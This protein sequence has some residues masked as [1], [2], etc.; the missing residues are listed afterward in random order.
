M[1]IKILCYFGLFLCS[2]FLIA[3]TTNDYYK[4]ESDDMVVAVYEYEPETSFLR[5]FFIIENDN[6]L[7]NVLKQY[8]S[9]LEQPSFKSNIDLYPLEKY[10]YFI[11]WIRTNDK[12]AS[13]TQNAI[14]IDNDTGRVHTDSKLSFYNDDEDIKYWVLY[15]IVDKEKLKDFDFS[16]QK[17][18]PFEYADKPNGG[19]E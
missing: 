18:E 8:D 2:I 17:K 9:F 6:D 3:C 16:E 7:K 15:W 11:D 13:I 1:K 4:I 12:I 14:I 5:S 19:I 10:T